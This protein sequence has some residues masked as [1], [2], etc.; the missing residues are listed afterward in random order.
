MQK[1]DFLEIVLLS[2][3]LGIDSIQTL[4]K[5]IKE[6]IQEED[7]GDIIKLLLRLVEEKQ[8]RN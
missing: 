5:V 7:N 8:S 6:N 4:W 2:N 1:F 3:I